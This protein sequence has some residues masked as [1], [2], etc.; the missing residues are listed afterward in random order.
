MRF[1]LSGQ[2]PLVAHFLHM[3]QMR[4]SVARGQGVRRTQVAKLPEVGQ[5]TYRELINETLHAQQALSKEYQ[6]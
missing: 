6:K 4:D 5:L 3:K 1:K 2:S